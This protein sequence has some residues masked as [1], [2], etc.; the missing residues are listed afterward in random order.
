MSLDALTIAALE[1]LVKKILPEL[2]KRL[3]QILMQ[4]QDQR[5]IDDA[6][7]LLLVECRELMTM[8]GESSH[9]PLPQTLAGELS[10]DEAAL[11][12]ADMDAPESQPMPSKGEDHELSDDEAAMLL[13]EMDAPLTPNQPPHT[14]EKSAV[15]TQAMT[16][17]LSDDEAAMLLAEM[18]APLSSPPPAA[19]AAGS[20]DMSDDEAAKIAQRIFD[21]FTTIARRYCEA[22]PLD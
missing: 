21:L 17:E 16:E 3:K 10:D 13:A 1:S 20:P 6:T 4:A 14:K 12:L 11:L 2:D 19:K 8:L 22:N 15:S 9:P 5:V 18:D 7:R